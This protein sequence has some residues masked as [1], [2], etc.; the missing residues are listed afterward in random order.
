[1]CRSFA[2]PG[3]LA[4]VRLIREDKA[5]RYDRAPYGRNTGLTHGKY[6]PG[7]LI[8][9]L[10]NHTTQNAAFTRMRECL[11]KRKD[12]ATPMTVWAPDRSGRILVE[13]VGAVIGVWNRGPSLR[14]WRRAG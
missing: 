1:M 11:S 12:Q 7:P 8:Q 4:W 13:G 9:F 5:P 3:E 2:L 14:M 6:K 10:V